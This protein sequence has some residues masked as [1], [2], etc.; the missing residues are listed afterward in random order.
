MKA[1]LFLTSLRDSICGAV[2]QRLIAVLFS[3]VVVAAAVGECR[4][5]SA[6]ELGGLI[7]QQIEARLSK[8]GVRAAA[9]AD[10]AEFVRRIY[11]DLHGT[12]PSLEEVKR[13]LGDPRPD[14]RTRL[15]DALL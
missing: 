10:D 6:P 12:V 3:F 4:A 13:F 14:K 9:I 5:A 1:R 7:D 8:E 15:I 2:L 11:L